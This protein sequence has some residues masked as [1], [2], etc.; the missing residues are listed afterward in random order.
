M[1]YLTLLNCR[2][3]TTTFVRSDITSRDM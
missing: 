1:L 2:I 3:S